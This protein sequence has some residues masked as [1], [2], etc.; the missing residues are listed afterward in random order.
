[1]WN[2]MVEAGVT[3]VLAIIGL[4]VIATLFSKNARTSSVLQAGF[5]GLANN[6]AVAQSPVTGSTV[7][8]N[9]SYPGSFGGFGS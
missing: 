7:T 3:I 4:A 5:S 6:I 2:T 1:M 9:L 8:P